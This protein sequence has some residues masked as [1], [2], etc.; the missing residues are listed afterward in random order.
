MNKKCFW[1]GKHTS[2]L[3]TV[4][5][6][7]RGKSEDALICSSTCETKLKDFVHYADSHIK[8][9][10][11]GIMLSIII[12]AVIF[13]WRV[14]IDGGGIGIFIILAGMGAA[15]IKYPFVTPQTVNWLGA[16]RAIISGRIIGVTNIILGI[17]I[18]IILS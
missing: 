3:N 12:G 11:I 9:Y 10:I 6:Q 1:C 5:L 4:Q 8:H 2:Q 13:S 14:S 17:V 18:W 15:L 7:F 16:K